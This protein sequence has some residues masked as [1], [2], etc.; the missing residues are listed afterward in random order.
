MKKIEPD[1]WK[2]FFAGIGLGILSFVF[3]NFL[4]PFQAA[5]KIVLTLGIVVSL[6]YFF[7]LLSLI[8][9]EGV[10]DVMDAIAGIIGGMIGIVFIM[11]ILHFAR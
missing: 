2:H 9:S 4:L 3:I 11:A 8:T 6:N 5:T 7:E 1:K 10:Y